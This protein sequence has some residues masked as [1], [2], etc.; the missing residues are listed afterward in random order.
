MNWWKVAAAAAGIGLGAAGI[1]KV[2]IDK[3]KKDLDNYLLPAP[4][5]TQSE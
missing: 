2:V 3:R 1:A 4:D 5:D